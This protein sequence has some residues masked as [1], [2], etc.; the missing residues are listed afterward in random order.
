MV[1]WDTSGKCIVTQKV[2]GFCRSSPAC[3][4]SLQR[5]DHPGAS[6]YPAPCIQS[7]PVPKEQN[8]PPICHHVWDE[9]HRFSDCMIVEHKA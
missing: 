7:I 6:V 8:S 1:R 9:M 5:S 4:S 3:R 2:D